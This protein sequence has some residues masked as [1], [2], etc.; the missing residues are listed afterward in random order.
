M[1]RPPNNLRR[2]TQDQEHIIIVDALR[3]VISGTGP[4]QP[5]R[6]PVFLS[7]T[8]SLPSTSGTGAEQQAPP[9]ML[10]LPDVAT[11][12]VCKIN[13]CLG[14]NFF[15][16]GKAVTTPGNN[17]AQANKNATRKRKGCYRGVRQRPWGKWAAEIR[18]PRRAARVWLGTFETAELAARAYDRAALEFRGVRAKLNFPQPPPQSECG[19]TVA[20]TGG[21][22]TEDGKAD[23]TI[24]PKAEVKV[25]NNAGEGAPWLERDDG[26]GVNEFWEKLEEEEELEEWT[27]MHL[28]P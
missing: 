19:S 12:P 23:Q 1:Q 21:D 18:D 20:N 7:S 16:P 5:E 11:C 27:A 8:S 10:S 9:T 2:I 4:T 28:P 6:I 3:H 14:C 17:S 25:D 15:A 26:R 24:K 22:V 13:G